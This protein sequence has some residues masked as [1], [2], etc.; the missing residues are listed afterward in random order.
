LK[1]PGDKG[2]ELEFD[3]DIT[4]DAEVEVILDRDSGHGIK[5]E[6]LDPCCLRLITLENLI[7]GAISLW[8]PITLNMGV[9]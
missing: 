8:G 6:V 1:I 9:N 5:G 2:L 3:L 4:D 7:C